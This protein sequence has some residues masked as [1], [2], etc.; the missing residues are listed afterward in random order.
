MQF[1]NR[2]N[3]LEI[4]LLILVSFSPL[5]P[6]VFQV[7]I[8]SVIIIRNIRFLN[9]ISVEKLI[10]I[11]IILMIFV[12]GIILDITNINNDS[13]SLLNYY[14]PLCFLVG[15][16]ISQ[17]Y[18]LK[19]FLSIFEENIYVFAIFSLIGVISYTFFKGFIMQLP[20]YNYYGTTHKTAIIFNVLV[21]EFG[22]VE[23]NAGI[24]W[25]PGAFQFL[26]NLGVYSYIKYN[27]SKKFLKLGIYGLAI[28]FTESTAGLIIF[29]ILTINI[30][31]THKYMRYS[32]VLFVFIFFNQIRELFTFQIEHKFF[33]SNSF[34]IRLEPMLNAIEV[35]A[36]NPLGLGNEAYNQN[37]FSMNLGSYDS[38][39]QMFI[40]YGYALLL[41][42][43]FVLLK[44]T[45]KELI[46]GL[47][48]IFTFISQSVWFFPLVTP[49]YFMVFN[50]EPK[51]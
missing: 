4:L 16:V 50:K 15:L 24:A 38:Y 18:N 49:F 19:D 21:T 51:D 46:L 48:L 29:L 2:L 20:S 13:F 43:I 30:F 25:E 6:Q 7:G 22:V 8:L 42:I 26:L 39:S 45:K 23:R 36:S 10:L 14:Y 34:S 17:K 35:G 1:S 32:I 9:K 11:F 47:I 31:M 28:I 3:K 33:G 41:T 44:I 5:I 12:I 37:L 40:R 27:N